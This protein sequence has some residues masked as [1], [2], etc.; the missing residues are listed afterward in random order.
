MQ[1]VPFSSDPWQ[2]FTCTLGDVSY[3]FQ[4]RYNDRNGLWTFNMERADGEDLS[5]V[6]STLQGVPIVCGYNLLKPYG[7]AI[8]AM[9][10]TDLEAGNH[11]AGPNDLGDRVL[12][13]W[14]DDADIAV[15]RDAE[16]PL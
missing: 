8:G 3:R 4:A 7:L 13:T 6:Y 5:S 15:Y 11:D 10:A 2:E 12:V 14:L 1:L 9:I 16:V